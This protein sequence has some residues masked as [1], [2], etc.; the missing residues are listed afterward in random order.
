MVDINGNIA[1]CIGDD[2]ISYASHIKGDFYSIQANMMKNSGVPI[3]MVLAYESSKGDL[4]DRMLVALEAAETAGADIRGKQS[5]VM[6]ISSGE[7]TGVK[8]KDIR[9]DL[10][11]EDHKNPA[12]ELRR[13][14]KNHRAYKHANVGD[15]HTEMNQIEKALIEYNN[16]AKLYPKNPELLYW[17]AVVLIN[18]ENIQKPLHIFKKVFAKNENLHLITPRLISTGFLKINEDILEMIIEQY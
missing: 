1:S 13:L 5:A 4:A 18:N 11:V 3:A 16:A 15:Y 14:I 9:L 8:W 17:A 10:R 7:P 12:K 6:I 2:C